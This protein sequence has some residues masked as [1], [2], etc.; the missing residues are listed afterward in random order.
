MNLPEPDINFY[1]KNLTAFLAQIERELQSQQQGWQCAR[2][3]QDELEAL[4]LDL[5]RYY[6]QS[7]HDR[8]MPL[9]RAEAEADMKK[10]YQLA[11][12]ENALKEDIFKNLK[13]SAQIYNIAKN[14]LHMLEHQLELID[15][16][17]LDAVRSQE[18]LLL[19]LA[20]AL[21]ETQTA[22]A[23]SVA[24]LRSQQSLGND[25]ELAR[26]LDVY[27]F[28]P[29]LGALW[30]I[31]DQDSSHFGR[32]FRRLQINLELMLKQL[33]R[34]S[35]PDEKAAELW[36][37]E[38]VELYKTENNLSH[39]KFTPALAEWYKQQIRPQLMLWAELLEAYIRQRNRKRIQL[40]ARKFSDWLQGLLYFLARTSAHADEPEAF[41]LEMCPALPAEASRLKELIRLL[42]AA[43]KHL[44]NL[45]KEYDEAAHPDL[46]IFIDAAAKMQSETWPELK[47]LCKTERAD[48]GL[49]NNMLAHVHDRFSWLEIQLDYLSLRSEHLHK[50]RQQYE[51]AASALTAYRDLLADM[52]SQLAKS[53]APR[54]LNRQYKDLDLRVE[55]VPV[56]CGEPFPADYYYLLQRDDLPMQDI[57]VKAEEGDIFLFR[58]DELKDELVPRI[59]LE[60]DDQGEDDD[61]PGNDDKMES[62]D[63][64][65]DNEKL[66]DNNHLEIDD[67][68]E[69]HVK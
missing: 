24:A 54:N 62:N 28:Q 59:L 69:S 2:L 27:P 53:F 44:Q 9:Y 63:Q 42:T 21:K 22:V 39:K 10:L 30:M 37:V 45:I 36:E 29:A 52:K 7:F 6:Y 20:Y 15:G 41:L 50:M 18:K 8:F 31:W 13:R 34:I 60:D 65:E 57:I 61:K 56:T 48:Y 11:R 67:E 43:N 33:D 23:H 26:H 64:P 5:N 38:L 32:D 47:A 51:Q 17:R 55:H 3:D 35:A 58:L 1:M 25:R 14:G 4:I 68:D 12:D 19:E 16:L 49:L 46:S 40:T 66:K